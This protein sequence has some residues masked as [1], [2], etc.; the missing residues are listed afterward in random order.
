MSLGTISLLRVLEQKEIMRIGG[1]SMIIDVR[2]IA[3]TSKDH[4]Q[5]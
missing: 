3:A 4:G 5:W 1:Q 2:V